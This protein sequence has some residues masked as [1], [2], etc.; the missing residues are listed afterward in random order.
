MMVTSTR[1]ALVLGVWSGLSMAMAAGP[2]LGI[3]TA[4]GNFQLDHA[5]VSGNAT[6]TDGAVVETGDVA[7]SLH[8]N[9][10]ARLR[11]GANSKATVHENRLVL[12]S[13]FGEISGNGDYALESASYWIKPSDA[14]STGQVYRADEQ[15]VQVASTAGSLR[16]FDPRGLQIANVVAGGA[17]LG[18][19]MQVGGAAPPSSFLGCLLKSGD[20][21]VLFD[22]ATRLTIEIR[23]DETTL[24]GEWGNRVQINGTTDTSGQSQVAAQIVNMTTLTRIG[25]GGCEPVAQAIGAQLPPTPPTAPG[26][27]RPLPN[28]PA[29]GGGGMSAGTKIAILAAIGG[30]GAGA[31]AFL[32]KGK[33]SRSN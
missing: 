6:L 9:N 4:N 28:P 2:S 3:I 19:S 31:A 26:G 32:V 11:L 20:T 18:F 24:A 10:G 7:S 1:L 22:Q 5:T 16:V 23:G 8:L 13:G 30:G 12:D 17:V 25:V 29:T 33:S 15:T 27:T 14:G 21:F